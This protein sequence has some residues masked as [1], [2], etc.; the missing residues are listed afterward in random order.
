MLH[1]VVSS[2][3]RQAPTFRAVQT[4]VCIAI[5]NTL[6]PPSLYTHI[7]RFLDTE[8]PIWYELVLI[9]Q[10][11]RNYIPKN[12]LINNGRWKGRREIQKARAK[13]I[14]WSNLPIRI[15]LQRAQLNSQPLLLK[16]PQKSPVSYLRRHPHRLSH[17]SRVSLHFLFLIFNLFYQTVICVNYDFA[18]VI[19]LLTC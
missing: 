4:P 3:N 8:I 2:L 9:N 6:P 1:G 7:N 11:S 10:L 14:N 19:W 13:R 16:T 18:N 15:S 17:A 12:L 5:N